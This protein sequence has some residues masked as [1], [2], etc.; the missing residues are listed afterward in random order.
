MPVFFCKTHLISSF[1]VNVSS[2]PTGIL[3]EE[4]VIFTQ[5]LILHFQ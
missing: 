5:S 2:V 3:T 4:N 1:R